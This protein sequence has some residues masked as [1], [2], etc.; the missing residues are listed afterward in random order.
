MRSSCYLIA[1]ASFLIFGCAKNSEV[2]SIGTIDQ[3]TDSAPGAVNCVIPQTRTSLDASLNV[4]WNSGDQIRI[5]STDYPSGKAYSTKSEDTGKGIFAPVGE[6]VPIGTRYAVYPASA[7]S[8]AVLSGESLD[9]D[10]SSFKEQDYSSVLD[11]SSDVDGLPMVS[12][13]TDS[14]FVFLNVCGGLRLQITD[15]QGLDV[16]LSSVVATAN[17]KEQI[18]GKATVNL[19]TGAVA[20]RSGEVDNSITVTCAGGASISNAQNNE[21]K[22]GVVI[23]LPAGTYSSGFSFVVTDIQGRVIRKSTT[24]PIT[25]EAGVVTPLKNLPLTLY[26]GKANSYFAS[27]AGNVNVDITPYY[28]LSEKYSY[29]NKPAM[30]AD[31]KAVGTATSAKILWQQTISSASGDVVS[32]PSIEGTTLI[33]PAT[34]TFGNALVAICDVSG[35]I[36]WSYHI[37]ISDPVDVPYQN[38]SLGSFKMMDR[39]LGALTTTLKD[40][41]SYGMFYQWGRKDPFPRPHNISRPTGSPYSVTDIELTPNA[42]M[43]VETGTIGYTIKHPDTRL[44]A[45]ANWLYSGNNTGLWGNSDEKHTKATGTK[46]VYDPCPEGYRVADPACYAMGWVKDAAYCN[47]N[48]GYTFTT[49]S[50]S[51][52]STYATGGYLDN[53]SNAVMFHEYRGYL[54]TNAKGDTGAYRFYFNNSS[55]SFTTLMT[56]AYALPLRCVKIN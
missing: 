21:D 2:D 14:T 12:K 30:D 24:S 3:K 39:N 45:T 43:T 6:E 7:V 49:D 15:Y 48:Y 44:F 46:T 8:G 25:V 55:I 11:I 38:D 50:G 29:D 52:T 56:E 26:Y 18:S 34:G 28:T 35:N 5:F 31:G 36:L 1:V 22:S 10:F 40:Q 37:W 54:W 32:V 19:V 17:G 20:L 4:L 16:K 9:V 33:V 42:S 23:F 27:S 41:N 53:D 47:A 13:S 51:A